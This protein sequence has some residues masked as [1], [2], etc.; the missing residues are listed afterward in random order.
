MSACNSHEKKNTEPED[1]DKEA[2]S[3]TTT[4]T[5]DNEMELDDAKPRKSKREVARLQEARKARQ[6]SK[7]R[8]SRSRPRN[9][10]E[11]PAHKLKKKAGKR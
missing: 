10:K 2:T 7:L 9:Q 1:A 6:I 11:F 3:T 5:K 8:G 4:T